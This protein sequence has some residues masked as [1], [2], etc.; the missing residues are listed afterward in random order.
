LLSPTTIFNLTRTNP[1]GVFT[2]LP[3]HATA[4]QSANKHYIVAVSHPTVSVRIVALVRS[5]LNPTTLTDRILAGLP[6]L[7]GVYVD[8]LTGEMVAILGG[9]IAEKILFFQRAIVGL[10]TAHGLYISWYTTTDRGVNSTWLG[11]SRI[12]QGEGS[13][14]P[15]GWLDKP[16]ATLVFI[17]ELVG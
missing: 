6:P 17:V 15:M 7:S 14:L 16:L 8:F 12:F 1:N 4:P 3:P 9:G 2:H 10:R 5:L 13:T 11:G